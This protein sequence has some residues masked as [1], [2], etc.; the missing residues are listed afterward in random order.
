LDCFSDDH[1]RTIGLLSEMVSLKEGYFEE[2]I[3]YTDPREANQ[4]I[5]NS[6]IIFMDCDS[7]ILRVCELIRVLIGSKQHSKEFLEFEIGK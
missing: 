5:L 6:I 3:A 7:Q 1:I 2:V 4:R